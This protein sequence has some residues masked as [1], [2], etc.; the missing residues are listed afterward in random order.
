[1]EDRSLWQIHFLKNLYR[2][3]LPV[4]NIT[5]IKATIILIPTFLLNKAQRLCLCKIF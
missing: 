5:V 2:L 1:M 3:W 4:D